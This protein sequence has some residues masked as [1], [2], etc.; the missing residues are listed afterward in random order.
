VVPLGDGKQLLAAAAAL[1]ADL[2]NAMRAD[3]ESVAEP[4]S[5]MHAGAR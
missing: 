4:I 2:L 1:R 3:V 5:V